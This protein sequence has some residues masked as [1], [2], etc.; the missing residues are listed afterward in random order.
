M[1]WE[2]RAVIL[3]KNHFEALKQVWFPF[4]T[5]DELKKSSLI[6]R[7]LRN[8][9][10]SLEKVDPKILLGKTLNPNSLNNPGQGQGESQYSRPVWK[11][12]DT[13]SQ[14]VLQAMC[15]PQEK[16][17]GL[18]TSIDSQKAVRGGKSSVRSQRTQADPIEKPVH[19]PIF[20]Y[21]VYPQ[22]MVPRLTFRDQG[23]LIIA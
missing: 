10:L 19:L 15:V 18:W 22:W 6:K 3:L 12:K 14:A 20:P 9:L 5:K 2:E 8:P 23:M 1:Q 13:I 4:N 17:A 16:T 7:G 11:V 21:T